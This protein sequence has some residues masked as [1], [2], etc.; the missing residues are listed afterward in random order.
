[1]DDISDHKKVVVVVS[2]G[3]KLNEIENVTS[4][5]GLRKVATTLSMQQGNHK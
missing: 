2:D 3:N 4:G 1:M 5:G